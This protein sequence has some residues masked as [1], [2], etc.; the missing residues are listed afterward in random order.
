MSDPQD[1]TTRDLNAVFAEVDKAYDRWGVSITAGPMEQ[2]RQEV[3]SARYAAQVTGGAV[4]YHG[5][6]P[7]A[8]FRGNDLVDVLREA[9]VFVAENAL[10]P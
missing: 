8:I 1:L 10:H 9:L 5:T 4:D 7:I 3:F 6:A 2:Y